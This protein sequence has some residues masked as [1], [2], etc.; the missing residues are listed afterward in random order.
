MG[1]FSGQ[2][3]HRNKPGNK[4]KEAE[5]HRYTLDTGLGQQE[6]GDRPRDAFRILIRFINRS[7][8]GKARREH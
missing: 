4:H 8:D 5:K 2:E 3:T 6:G 1:R 7:A